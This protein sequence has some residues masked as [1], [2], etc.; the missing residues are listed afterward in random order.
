HVFKV[1]TRFKMNLLQDSNP[2]LAELKLEA[3]GGGGAVPDL[4]QTWAEYYLK[5]WRHIL[6]WSMI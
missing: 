2:C 3:C 1:A 6:L 5:H 4:L